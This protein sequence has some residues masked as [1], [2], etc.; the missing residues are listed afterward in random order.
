MVIAGTLDALAGVPVVAHIALLTREASVARG[1]AT[2]LRPHCRGPPGHLGHGNV[3]VDPRYGGTLHVPGNRGSHQNGVDAGEHT[4]V[5]LPGGG[6]IGAA[7]S[8]AP[9]LLINRNT[10]PFLF[11][12]VTFRVKRVMQSL[13]LIFN[14]LS[15]NLL[16]LPRPLPIMMTSE[17]LRGAT[18]PPVTVN[19]C[20]TVML[21]PYAVIL[22]PRN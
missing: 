15:N 17:S 22:L 3:H 11:V 14:S 20:T 2:L 21:P 6:P 7:S 1:T 4:E 10:L 9:A 12:R 19:L 18:F 16:T 5:L 8:K 13:I